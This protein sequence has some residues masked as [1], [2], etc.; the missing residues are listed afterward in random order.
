MITSDDFITLSFSKI[1]NPLSVEPDNGFGRFDSA[2]MKHYP[3][4]RPVYAGLIIMPPMVRIRRLASLIFISKLS[5]L[6]FYGVFVAFSGGFV[7]DNLAPTFCLTNDCRQST[8]TG[9][10]TVVSVGCFQGL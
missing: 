8:F 9:T 7:N 4:S 1:K 3:P 10:A 2:V 6:L 5:R